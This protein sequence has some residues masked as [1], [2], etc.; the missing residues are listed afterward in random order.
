MCVVCIGVYVGGETLILRKIPH[1]CYSPELECLFH[2]PWLENLRRSDWLWFVSLSPSPLWQIHVIAELQLA[3]ILVQWPY[4][5]IA[6]SLGKSLWHF[7]WELQQRPL[8]SHTGPVFFDYAVCQDMYLTLNP[9]TGNPTA[10]S[11]VFLILGFTDAPPQLKIYNSLSYRTVWTD[12]RMEIL[13]DIIYRCKAAYDL[14]GL[15]SLFFREKQLKQAACGAV[16]LWCSGHRGKQ[17]SGN[18]RPASST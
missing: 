7:C 2:S 8:L 15:C 3:P 10:R 14:Y 5:E 12:N 13:L 16:H 1:T 11:V 18:L 6:G 4:L 17:I 9:R